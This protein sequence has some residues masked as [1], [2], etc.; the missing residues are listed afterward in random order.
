MPEGTVTFVTA[1][2]GNS[3]EVV[4]MGPDVPGSPGKSGDSGESSCAWC[5]V[6]SRAEGLA[7]KT[8]CCAVAKLG[9]SRKTR[10]GQPNSSQDVKYIAI[11]SSYIIILCT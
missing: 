6:V 1:L 10:V 4:V 8:R 7:R 11:N 2:V 9:L 3:L 5:C